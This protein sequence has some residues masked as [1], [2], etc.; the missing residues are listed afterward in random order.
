MIQSG[1]QDSHQSQWPYSM[2]TKE[3]KESMKHL[4]A[5]VFDVMST[6]GTSVLT[7]KLLLCVTVA[8]VNK[9]HVIPKSMPVEQLN[10]EIFLHQCKVVFQEKFC[11][12]KF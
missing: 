3:T 10:T 8:M 1:K 2:N 6:N 5:C 12:K 4:S 11:S 7:L 9:T